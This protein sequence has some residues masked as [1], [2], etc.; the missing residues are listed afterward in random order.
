MIVR[1]CIRVAMLAVY[2][3]GNKSCSAG[4]LIP[5]SQSNRADWVS[6]ENVTVGVH[7][8]HRIYIC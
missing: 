8:K 4:V 3:T 1:R 7:P 6:Q 2:F 5:V